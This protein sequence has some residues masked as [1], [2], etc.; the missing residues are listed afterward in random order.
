MDLED[1]YRQAAEAILAAD[2]LLIGAGAGMGVDSGLPDFRGPAAPRDLQFIPGSSGSHFRLLAGSMA[3]DCTGRKYRG[4]R[5]HDG[6]TRPSAS[7]DFA[8]KRSGPPRRK[9]ATKWSILRVLVRLVAAAS[10]LGAGTV[11]AATYIWTGGTGGTWDTSSSNWSGGPP[12]PWDATTGS[13]NI[14]DFN[15]ASLNAMVSGSIYTNGIIFDQAGTLSSGTII[16]TGPSPTITTNFNGAISSALTG[17][18]GLTKQGAGSLTLSNENTI[19][20]TVTVNAGTLYTAAGNAATGA[21]GSATF[22][23][24]NSGGTISVGGDNSFDGNLNGTSD[25]KTILINAGGILGNSGNSTNH[26]SAVVL[27]GGTLSAAIAN[28]HYGS[29]NF[30]HGVSTPGNGA[31]SFISGGNAALSQAGGTVFNVGPTDTL[32]VS[33]TLAHVPATDVPDTGLTKTGNGL[34]ILGGANTYTG[35]TTISAGTLQVGDGTAGH[36]GSILGNIVNN[37]SLDGY[38]ATLSLQGNDLELNVTPEPCTVALL[39]ACAAGLVGYGLR[40]R[41]VARSATKPTAF[42]HEEPQDDGP[43]ILSMPSRWTQAARRAA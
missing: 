15:T 29:W 10:I 42:D 7:A 36:D 33:T 34:L 20:G 35:G 25:S 23:V 30:D 31:T 6:M 24:I 14:A 32:S 17:S 12:T 27:N 16:L 37:A 26:L 19:T 2:A 28:S 13:S 5:P 11:E 40:R 22:I 41:R 8:R 38:P 1:A 3:R 9:W 4:P 43:A 39:A 18:N 21:I